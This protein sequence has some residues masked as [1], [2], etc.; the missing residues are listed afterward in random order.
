[1]I[2]VTFHAVSLISIIHDI[3]ESF[4]LRDF[5]SIDMSFSFFWLPQY[6]TGNQQLYLFSWRT[7]TDL[8]RVWLVSRLSQAAANFILAAGLLWP[9]VFWTTSLCSGTKKEMSQNIAF[10]TYLPVW[11]LFPLCSKDLNVWVQWHKQRSAV[12]NGD[13]SGVNTGDS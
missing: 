10:E 4:I 3:W 9:F 12:C 8:I 6:R 11:K 5:H 13:A 7:P 1:M 2:L